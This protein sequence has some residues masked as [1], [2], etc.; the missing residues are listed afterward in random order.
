[1]REIFTYGSVGGAPGNRCFYLEVENQGLGLSKFL[2]HPTATLLLTSSSYPL[3][4][5]EFKR[6]LPPKRVAF[7]VS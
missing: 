3:F 7:S 5:T 6:S 2:S 1:M 4:S